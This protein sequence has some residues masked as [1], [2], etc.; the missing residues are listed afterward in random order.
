MGGFRL[1]LG[2]LLGAGDMG[3]YVT[4]DG[5]DATPADVL[6]IALAGPAANV[7]GSFVTGWPALRAGSDPT[8]CCLCAC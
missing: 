8:S 1:E 4:Y 7:A 2:R 5:R 3:G 6:V